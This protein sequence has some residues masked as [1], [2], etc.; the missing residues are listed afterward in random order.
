ML[1]DFPCHHATLSRYQPLRKR[2][3]ENYTMQEFEHIVPQRSKVPAMS[4]FKRGMRCLTLLPAFADCALGRTFSA[5]F[6]CRQQRL[7]MNTCMVSHATQDEQD[8][9]R[10]EWFALRLQRQKEREAKEVRRKE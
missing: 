9:A 8:A 2:K 10:E 4:A 6:V 1:H 7:S 3:Y 5:P